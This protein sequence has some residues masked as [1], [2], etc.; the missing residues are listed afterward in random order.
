MFGKQRSDW[1]EDAGEGHKVFVERAASIHQVQAGRQTRQPAERH[2][3]TRM[4]IYNL[5]L[6]QNALN[7]YHGNQHPDQHAEQGD[8]VSTARRKKQQTGEESEEWSSSLVFKSSQNLRAPSSL[9]LT[10]HYKDADSGWSLPS[11]PHL[12]FGVRLVLL[13]VTITPWGLFGVY[14]RVGS[15]V[16]WYHF[17][18][19]MWF[20]VILL[21]L[22]LFRPR[23]TRS[24]CRKNGGHLYVCKC[25]FSLHIYTFRPALRTLALSSTNKP[26][27]PDSNYQSN[28]TL[29]TQLLVS[30]CHCEAWRDAEIRIWPGTGVWWEEVSAVVLSGGGDGAGSD[31][32]ARYYTD[33]LLIGVTGSASRSHDELKYCITAAALNE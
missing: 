12:S 18:D 6:T 32:Q 23:G 5:G 13:L 29:H 14:C 1:L 16:V 27:H 9:R 20:C 31:L 2:I 33:D 17:V 11:C 28:C 30:M 25:T 24:L 7:R 3:H 15:F 21:F 8:V 19:I 26:H 4:K 22:S 10:W